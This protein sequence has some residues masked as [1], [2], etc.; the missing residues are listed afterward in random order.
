ML[1]ENLIMAGEV[2]LP[3]MPRDLVDKLLIWHDSKKT[4][5]TN[6]GA[7]ALYYPWV[8]TKIRDNEGD[9]LIDI[10]ESIPGSPWNS[11]F[12]EEFPELVKF[13]NQL[14]LKTVGRIILLE[15]IKPCTPHIDLSSMYYTDTTYEPCNYRMTLRESKSNGFYVQAI[16]KEDFG[17]GPRR[18]KT[19]IYDKN[20][21]KPK[22]GNWWVLNNWCCQHGS[23][24]DEGDNKVLISIQGTPSEDHRVLL[25]SLT[26]VIYHPEFNLE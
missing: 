15:T 20:F 12:V 2:N 7:T 24:W 6:K 16:P 13:L 17:T 1:K 3:S 4:V 9:N 22:I 25:K 8:H 11:D 18:D 5:L 23:E 21:F 14:P 10:D 19:S 26:N